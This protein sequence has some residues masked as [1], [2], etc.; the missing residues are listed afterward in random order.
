MEADCPGT[1]RR[2]AA[3]AVI[4][5]INRPWAG[6][7]NFLDVFRLSLALAGQNPRNRPGRQA[8][9]SIQIINPANLHFIHLQPEFYHEKGAKE[10]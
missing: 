5:A 8:H 3:R 6:T 10:R 2:K 7:L 9:L 4:A 1:P